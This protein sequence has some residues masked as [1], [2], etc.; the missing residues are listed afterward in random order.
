MILVGVFFM[1]GIVGVLMFMVEVRLVFVLEMG[2]EV[3]FGDVVRGEICFRGN[4]MFFGYY[5]R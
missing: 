1:V 2:Y 5:K 4:L 3:F